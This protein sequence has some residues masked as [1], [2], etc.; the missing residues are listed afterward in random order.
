MAAET[1]SVDHLAIATRDFRST[2]SSAAPVSFPTSCFSYVTGA[3]NPGFLGFC[4]GG[5]RA[6]VGMPENAESPL[7]VANGLAV[8]LSS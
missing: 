2:V 7:A 5:L 3:L 1:A 8:F 6:G 4:R